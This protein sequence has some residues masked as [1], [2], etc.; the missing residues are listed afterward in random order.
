[1]KNLLSSI[2]LSKNL[3]IKEYRTIILCVVLYKCE[4]LSLKLREE[5]R[6]MLFNNMVLRKIFGHRLD[7]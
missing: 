2:F 6:L 5:P 4:T 1:V 3:K 7:A